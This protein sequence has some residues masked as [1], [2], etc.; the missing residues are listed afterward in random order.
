MESSG[1]FDPFS[2]KQADL[3]YDKSRNILEKGLEE[4][5]E[6]GTKLL[7]EK[8]YDE[9]RNFITEKTR[10][11]DRERDIKELR[12]YSLIDLN[13][14]IASNREGLKSGWPAI[15]KDVR[16]PQEALTIIAGQPSHG[17]TTILLNLFLNCIKQYPEQKFL[18]YSYEENSKQLILKSIMNLSEYCFDEKNNYTKFEEHIKNGDT[19]IPQINDAVQRI[20]NLT[21]SKR[22]WFLDHG[23]ELEDL[24]NE[25]NFLCNEQH[26]GGVF[27]DYIQR[28]KIKDSLNDRHKDL[29]IISNELLRMAKFYKIPIILGAQL[30]K[31]EKIDNKVHLDQLRDAGYIEQD[32]NLILGVYN[33]SMI[34]A[35]DG[36]S[37]KEQLVDLTLSI[38]KN[39][40]GAVNSNTVLRFDRPVLKIRDF[41]TKKI[42][43]T[44]SKLTRL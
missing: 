29:Q 18:F 2:T 10:G 41:S 35:R 12:P 21:K 11:L 22:M 7:K 6:H 30:E 36:V 26:I 24:N 33:K 39:R 9:L 43:N 16:I 19:S 31:G 8:R 32:A 40:N 3:M 37:V 13:E 23:P 15:D 14:D 5:L 38:L 4:I 42:N 27:I 17:K 1:T 44:K 25:L 34:K 20:E 28:M